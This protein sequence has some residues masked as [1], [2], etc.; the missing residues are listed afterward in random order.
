MYDAPISIKNES[1]RE[2]IKDL[3]PDEIMLRLN[4]DSLRYELGTLEP[5]TGIIDSIILDCD[6]PV[7]EI[8]IYLK[9]R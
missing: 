6:I 3:L 9:E 8:F 5:F 7:E 2:L 1:L 4:G